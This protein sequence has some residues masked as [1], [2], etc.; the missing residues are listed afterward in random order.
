[1]LNYARSQVYYQPIGQPDAPEL[2]AAIVS[3]A[4]DYATYVSP[5]NRSIA[6]SGALRQSQTRGLPHQADGYHGQG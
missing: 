2:E 5:N 3:I 1:V 6:A 4:G